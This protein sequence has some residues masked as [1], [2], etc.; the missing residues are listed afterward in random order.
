M[1]HLVC[2]TRAL[3]A[4]VSVRTIVFPEDGHALDRVQTEYEQWLNV[5]WDMKRTTS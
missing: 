3:A 1:L 4:G 2:G 5:A